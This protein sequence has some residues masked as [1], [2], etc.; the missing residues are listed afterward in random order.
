MKMIPQAYHETLSGNAAGEVK[1]KY[2]RL[3]GEPVSETKPFSSEL[4]FLS[5]VFRALTQF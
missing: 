2:A 1:E 3:R 5:V 4:Q